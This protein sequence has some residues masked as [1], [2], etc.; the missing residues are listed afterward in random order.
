[1]E[2]GG[3]AALVVDPMTH[4]HSGSSGAPGHQLGL[5]GVDSAA[6]LGSR[7]SDRQGG[8]RGGDSGRA[9]SRRD[10]NDSNDIDLMQTVAANAVRCGY[11]LVGGHERVYA[12]VGTGEEVARVPRYEE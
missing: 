9:V 10:S 11:L 8:R 5:F 2:L 7:Q 1:M 12:R 4:Q 3:R 6:T